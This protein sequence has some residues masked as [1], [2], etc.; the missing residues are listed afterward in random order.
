[1]Y[2]TCSNCIYLNNC[3]YTPLEEWEERFSYPPCRWISKQHSDYIR[4]YNFKIMND[5][6]Y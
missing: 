2:T 3:Y 1:M 6:E 5:F 4:E